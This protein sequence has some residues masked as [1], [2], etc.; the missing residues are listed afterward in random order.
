[1]K[2]KIIGFSIVTAVCLVVWAVATF[3]TFKNA[4][5]PDFL[6]GFSLGMGSVFAIALIYQI[7]IALQRKIVLQ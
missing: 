2:N 4:K 7:V 1:M 5:I 3:A 6:G